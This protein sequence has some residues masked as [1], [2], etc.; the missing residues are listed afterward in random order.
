MR[1]TGWLPR[2]LAGLALALAVLLVGLAAPA[3]QAGVV[4]PAVAE[5]LDPKAC[6]DCA[7]RPPAPVYGP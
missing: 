6:V 2:W 5:P 1:G 7:A 4:R 3:A